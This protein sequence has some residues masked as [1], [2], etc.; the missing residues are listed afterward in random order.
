MTNPTPVKPHVRCAGCGWQCRRPADH[1][2]RFGDCPKC[3]V[4]S[5]GLLADVAVGAPAATRVR[6]ADIVVEDRLR[7]PGEDVEGLATS[8]SKLGLL[9]PL[10][11]REDLRLVAGRR[12][13]LAVESLG[14][15]EVPAVVLTG[16]DVAA[17]LAEIDE[18][19]ERQELSALQ[20][21]QH[22]KRRQE[23]YES[24]HPATKHGGDRRSPD[25][26]SD[27]PSFAA[28]TAART[29]T[30]SRS[31]QRQVRRAERI[32]PDVQERIEG[33]GLAQQ[34]V[35][36]DAIAK[37]DHEAQRDVV[38]R[39]LSGGS[40]SVRHAV[41]S[42]SRE[43]R[44]DSIGQACDLPTGQRFAVVYADPPWRYDDTTTDPSRAIE[45][46]YPTME[47]HD[48]ELQAVEALCTDDAVLLLWVPSPKLEEGI[49]VLR[50]WGFTYRTGAVWTKDRL[51]MGYL[52]RQRHEHLLLGVRGSMPT[53]AEGDRPDSVIEA[54]RGEHSAK[55]DLYEMIDAM[56]PGVA[57]IEFFA[58]REVPDGW[59]A[60]GNESK[61]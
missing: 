38:E 11:V 13:M 41:Q 10:V 6:L 49:G 53:P 37:L 34:G 14:W 28:D 56:W 59:T 44:L 48:V 43:Q 26:G 39:V 12:R 5:V 18:N 3:F 24:Q 22:L 31:V 46:H 58:R 17:Q 23:L 54:P 30:S 55:P 16:D 33:T 61:G 7:A 36:L 21:A 51:G 9:Q 42:R 27:A 15:S 40:K 29:G 19:L 60:W 20:R 47:L 32:A 1:L 57:K 25:A 35:E 8:I 2:G 50:A 45:N 52:F 4:G